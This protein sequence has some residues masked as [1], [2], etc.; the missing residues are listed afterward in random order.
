VAA[1]ECYA[2]K[3]H[4][5][6]CIRRRNELLY[7]INKLKGFIG[8]HSDNSGAPYMHFLFKTRECRDAALKEWQ[9]I[10]MTVRKEHRTAMVDEKYFAPDYKVPPFEELFEDDEYGELMR[11]IKEGIRDQLREEY[12][13]KSMVYTNEIQSLKSEIC[14][15]KAE[16]DKAEYI[17][18]LTS[19]NVNVN[20]QNGKP[21]KSNLIS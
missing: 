20:G 13:M 16:L 1:V 18:D 5:D 21:R 10:Y 12:E 2:L 7:D 11:E 19:K 9:G 6:E 8:V 3:V 15:L 17:A 14:K 4:T